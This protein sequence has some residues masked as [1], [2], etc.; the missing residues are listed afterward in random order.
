MQELNYLRRKILEAMG[1]RTEYVASGAAKDYASYQRVVGELSGLSLALD[2]IEDL[3]Q[4][5]EKANDD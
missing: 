4:N 5:I 3:Q 1:N 2:E